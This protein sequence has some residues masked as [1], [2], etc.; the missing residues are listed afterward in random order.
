MQLLVFV[1]ASLMVV[2]GALGVV[3]YRHPVHAALSLVL[4]GDQVEVKLSRKSLGDRGPG[5]AL[6]L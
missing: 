2:G 6:G 5:S 3:L 1:V 4:T